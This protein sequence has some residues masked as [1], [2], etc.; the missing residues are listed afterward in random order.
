MSARQDEAEK[1]V[2]DHLFET[3]DDL[4]DSV[5]A[6]GAPVGDVIDALL[7]DTPYGI[8]HICEVIQTLHRHG[9]IYQPSDRT[10]RP[11]NPDKKA[12]ADGGEPDGAVD[13]D[14]DDAEQSAREFLEGE[15]AALGVPQHDAIAP[16]DVVIDLVTRQPLY[17]QSISAPTVVEHYEREGFDIASYKTHPWLPVTLDDSVY[18]CIYI[19]DIDGLHSF[20]DTYD[21]PGGRLARVPV[22]LAGG[23]E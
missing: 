12:I 7:N 9:E 22:E 15:L 16:G 20:S 6:V 2:R 1:S 4:E 21:M 23:E 10:I 14:Y 3:I 18:E 19:G 8:G 17:V 13:N 5:D 11:T